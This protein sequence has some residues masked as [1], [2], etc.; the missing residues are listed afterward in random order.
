MQLRSHAPLRANSL[1]VRAGNAC[2]RRGFMPYAMC[3]VFDDTMPRVGAAGA[4][5]D[6][7]LQGYVTEVRGADA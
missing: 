1:F 6:V 2:C 7:L 3:A 4:M 5:P